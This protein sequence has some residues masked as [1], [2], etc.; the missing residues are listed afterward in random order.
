MLQCSIKTILI[1]GK[2]KH[3][4]EVHKKWSVKKIGYKGK[5]NKF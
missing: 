1:H 2:L 5:I 3:E 4:I